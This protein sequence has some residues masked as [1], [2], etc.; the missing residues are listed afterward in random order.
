VSKVLNRFDE[1]DVDLDGIPVH[2]WEGGVG[3]AVV[4][5]HGSGAGAATLSNFRRVLDPIAESTHVLAADLIGFGQSGLK[6]TEPFFD[7][8]LWVTQLQMLIDRL[9]QESVVVVG[10][11]LSGAIALKTAARDRR[12][13]AVITT[14][15]MGA[16]GKG[17]G[18]RWLF[19]E[20]REAVLATVERTFYDTSLA[21][22]AEVQRRENVLNR[23]GYREYFEQMFAGEPEQYVRAAQLRPEELAAIT[24]PVLLMHGTADASFAP[25]DSSLVLAKSIER[26]DVYLLSHCAH[27][28]AHERPD[29][30]IASVRTVV[31]RTAGTQQGAT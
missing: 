10:H 27:S 26:A 23:P 11:S 13:A 1:F 22:D 20:S 29:E 7:M 6:K 31:A 25:A 3:P 28:V 15:T 19:P 9:G 2:C 5:L 14:G 18:T 12:I 16:P 8:E 30:F 17:A 24:C 21:E 4:F